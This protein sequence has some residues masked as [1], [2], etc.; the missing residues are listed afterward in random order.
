MLADSRPYSDIIHWLTDRGYSAFNKVNLHNW[1]IT[2]FRDWMC[3][4]KCET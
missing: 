4:S 3:A 1:R 2:G